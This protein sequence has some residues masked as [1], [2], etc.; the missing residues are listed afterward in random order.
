MIRRMV[1]R[2]LSALFPKQDAEHRRD[3]ARGR[4]ACPA[5]ASSATSASRSGPARSSRWPA[6][7]V[8][9]APRS[10]RRSSASTAYDTG[11][12]PLPRQAAQ[13]RLA[14]RRDG[15]RH[16]AGP[17]GPPPAGPDHGALDRAQRDAAAQ[18]A[19]W[20]GSACCFGGAER[21]EARELDRA[22]ADQA[23]PALRPG[24]HA[25][26]RQPAEG[27][28]GQVAGHRPEAADRRRA[29]PRHRRRHQGRGAPADVVA[30]GRRARRRDGLVRAARGARHGRPDRRPARGPRRRPAHPGRGHRGDAS[31]TPPW[32]S[33]S[34]H[35]AP[36]ERGQRQAGSSLPAVPATDRGR[37]SR[38][39]TRE[40]GIILALV[41]AGRLH[42][43]RQPALPVRAEH[44]RHPAEH[45]DPRGDGGRPGGRGDHPQHRPVGRLGARPQR[46][47]RRHHDER[48]PGPAD[49]RRDRWSASPSARCAA[50]STASWS[51]SARCPRWWS[52]SARST[53]SAASP[54]RGPAA[55]QVN[56]DELPPALP[57]LRQRLDPGHPVAGADRAGR[58]SA[59]SRW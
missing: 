47:H 39:K 54:T 16:G 22:A 1:G 9:A 50:C 24:R 13:A 31:C 29:D 42:R 36:S 48:Q 5:R 10:C 57:D 14:A 43:R 51:G 19:R 2:D 52:R 32:V 35:D 49:D 3:G 23:G 12:G 8:P 21:R 46:L 40:L 53:S 17:R 55:Q 4:A 58:W 59:A 30:G 34:P 25:V 56:A 15:G 7:S 27:G 41:A 37:R 18:P 44:P 26:R 20:P 28:A 45:G 33:R 6:W 38:S 11:I